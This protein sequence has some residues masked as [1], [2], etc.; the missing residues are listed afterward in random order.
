MPRRTAI[1]APT[2]ASLP[3]TLRIPSSTHSLVK[4]LGRFS[5][6]SLLDLVLQWL[7]E[8]NVRACPPYLSGDNTQEEKD[9]DDNAANPYTPASSIEELRETYE[10]LRDRKGGKREIIDRILEGDWRYGISLRQLATVDIQ[11]IEDHPVGMRWT[12]LKLERISPSSSSRDNNNN[13]KSGDEISASSIPRLHASTFLRAIQREISP[14]VKAHYYISRSKTLPLTFVRIFV[15]D[16]PYQQPRQSSYIYTDSSRIVYLA[17]PDSAPF[18]YSSLISSPAKRTSTS[19][20]TSTEPPAQ[21][22][23]T[24]TRTLRKLVKDAI[25][26]ALSRPQERYV[27]APT[28][29]TAKSLHTLLALRGPGRTNAANGAFSIFADAVVEGRP[30]D[31]RLPHHVSPEVYALGAENVKETKQDESDLQDTATGPLLAGKPSQRRVLQNRNIFHPFEPESGDSKKRKLA[32]SSRF[33]TAGTNLSGS[34]TFSANNNNISQNTTASTPST[35]PTQPLPQ[36]AL[37]RLDIHIQDPP[38]SPQDDS[39]SPPPSSISS[40]GNNDDHRPTQ[41]TLSLSFHGT[42]IIVGLRQLA[43]LGVIDAKRMPGWMTGEEGV[44]FAVVRGGRVRRK[45]G[46]GGV[47]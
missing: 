24:D 30:L 15:V 27:L 32:V 4:A 44:S 1:R 43:D 6:S 37:D 16:S 17:F 39:S 38:P 26:T 18:V 41:T 12:A 10:E 47:G 7:D 25:P 14:L 21:H 2:A 34:G 11:Y 35:K 29:L 9:D 28:S 42:N 36:P 46:G 3:D 13:N 19:T 23:T 33:G 5:R 31:P 40:A 45:D 20:S 8:K 22:I